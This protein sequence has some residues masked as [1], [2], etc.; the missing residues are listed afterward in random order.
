MKFLNKET[1]ILLQECIDNSSN[2]P[3]VLAEKFEGI[4]DEEDTRLRN[5]I[6]SLI[7]NGYF[8]KLQWADN[9]PWF[10]TITEEGYDYFHKKHVYTFKAKE[11]PF[12]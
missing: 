2:F 5:R 1:E 7:D 9:V 12:F 6:N 10:G 8:S 4:S 11:Y 3:K